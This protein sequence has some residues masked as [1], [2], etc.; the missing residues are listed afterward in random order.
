MEQYKHGLFDSPNSPGHLKTEMHR[1]AMGVS[2]VVEVLSEG[3][4]WRGR[5]GRLQPR[6][7]QT[8]LRE[9]AGETH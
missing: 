2:D 9:L 8:A 5:P 4:E 7:L 3:G 6:L 1:L